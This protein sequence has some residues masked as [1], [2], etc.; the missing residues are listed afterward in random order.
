MVSL[1]RGRAVTQP[2]A[3][4]PD[5]ADRPA[6]KN[7]GEGLKREFS[8]WSIFALAFAF[9]SPIVALYGIFT[10][11][12]TTA[13]PAAW[14][15][16]FVVLAGQLLVA[17]VFA[18]LA[19]RWPFEGSLY[20]W[21]RRL[22]HEGFGWFTGW[23]YMWTLMIT[24]TAVS[25]GAAGFIPVVLGTDPFTPGTQ[26]V[27]AIGFVLFGTLMNVV[28]RT[29]LKI[30]MGASIIAEVIGSLGIGTVLLFFHNEHGPG[31]L[32]E[33]AGAGVGPGGYLWAGFFGAVAFIGWAYVGFDTAASVAEEVNEPTRDV[34]KAII[35]SLVTVALV[36]SYSSLALIL[37]IPDYGAVISGKVA[38]PV[39][40]TISY[41]LGSGITKPLFVLF[42]VGFTASL[43]AIQTNCSRIMWAFARAD[44]LPG[45]G[46]LKTLSPGAR[47][48]RGTVVT[49]CV[50]ASVLLVATQSENL[51]L[52]L[53]SMATGGFYISF[54]LPVAAALWV[55]LKGK[56]EPGQFSLGRWGL[57]VVAAASVWSVFEY[58]NIAWPRSE[59]VPWYQD[60]AV[61]V[62][63]GIVAALG[64]LAYIPGRHKIRAAEDRLAEDPTAVDWSEP[65]P[66][67]PS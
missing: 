49:T 37:A 55:R 27:V 34:P 42:I 62:M 64:V 44:V 9:I 14:W 24:M 22:I 65:N 47:L 52:T 29:T 20:Q 25:Y 21:A 50:I 59:G 13:G 11:S 12:I 48:P 7:E 54:A 15:G 39:A 35:L 43:I 33:S 40:D 8:L 45:S 56:W 16:F 41:Q 23:A 46:Y 51:Y 57:L 17:L 53:V 38:D 2:G 5:D 1:T 67:S 36:V 3:V 30:F 10:F 60:W 63:T 66:Q 61:F 19:S 26:L 28:S 58:V 6:V 4:A 32:F 18:E 31:V